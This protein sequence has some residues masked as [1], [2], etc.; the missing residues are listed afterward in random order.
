[1][2]KVQVTLRTMIYIKFDQYLDVVVFGILSFTSVHHLSIFGHLQNVSI[3]QLIK[4]LSFSFPSISYACLKLKFNFT[5]GINSI[6]F[7]FYLWL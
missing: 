6:Y 4:R 2:K 3:H 7:Y 5:S 1:M